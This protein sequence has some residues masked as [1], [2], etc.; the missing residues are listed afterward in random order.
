MHHLASTYR[1]SMQRYTRTY[2]LS[3]QT[4]IERCNYA[5]CFGEYN[6]EC[7]RECPEEMTSWIEGRRMD[8][9][10]EVDG[11]DDGRGNDN[12]CGTGGRGGGGQG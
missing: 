11:E 5:V 10:E 7:V 8:G 4:Q 9:V 6:L 12:D 2:R 1:V 3:I